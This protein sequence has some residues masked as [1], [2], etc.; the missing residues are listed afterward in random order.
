MNK[1]NVELK[2]MEARD[3][4]G[5]I[6]INTDAFD[7]DRD[8]VLPSGAQIENYMKNPVVQ[9]G[10]NYKEPWATIGR[11]NQIVLL[12]DRIEVDF[13]L[14]E[15]ANESDPMN[16]IRLLWNKEFV[17]TAS[18]GFIPFGEIEQNE[19]GG[20]DFNSWELLEWSLVPIPANQEA[21]RLAVKGFDNP[22]PIPG[23]YDDAPEPQ[24]KEE[25]EHRGDD[26]HDAI[27][28]TECEPAEP[29]TDEPTDD[30]SEPDDVKD[31][32]NQLQKT[33]EELK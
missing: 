19:L 10:H 22:P 16:I 18:I 7:R 4:G 26:P 23:D 31:F 20:Y 8:R 17:K 13:D 21:L 15:P 6:V 25:K 12:E 11:T 27:E 29:N 5:R 33:I 28:D 32:F 9:W 2:I 30:A 1:I 14:R 3:N 24:D